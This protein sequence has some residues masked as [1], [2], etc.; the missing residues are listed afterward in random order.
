MRPPGARATETWRILAVR[1]NG[2]DILLRADSASFALPT[3]A[4][5]VQERIAANIN[6]AVERD[7]GLRVI[8]LYEVTLGDH[9]SA[10]SPLY[11]AVAVVQPGQ[12]LPQGVSWNSILP[13][14]ADS[15]SRPEDYL[16]IHAFRSG[17]DAKGTE[18]TARP[19]LKPDWFAELTCWVRD[20]VRPHSF[21]LTG[22]FHQL[23]ASGTFSLIRFDTD[24]VPVWFKA[25]GEPN[26]RECPI[27]LALAGLCPP[28]FPR[29][30]ASEPRWNAWL[31]AHAP[32]DS[33]AAKAEVRSWETT[34]SS[35]ARLQIATIGET[36][37]LLKAGA[38][39][40]RIRTLLSRVE[41]F[42]QFIAESIGQLPVQSSKLL[43]LLEVCELRAT[44][45]LALEE[46]EGLG[47]MET[48]GHM[49]LNP[50]NIFCLADRSVFLDWAESF[51][52]CPIF[53]YEYLLQHFR[54][55]CPR[56][57]FLEDQIRNAYLQPWRN[58]L[59]SNEL[60]RAFL[61]SRLIALFGYAVTIWSSAGAGILPSPSEKSYLLSLVR[62]MKREAARR[63]K[64]RVLQ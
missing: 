49:D 11:H 22:K 64:E 20:A 8:S 55:T 35:L 10:G 41:A 39:D 2:G 21:C 50:G 47:I 24:Q 14:T 44:I 3:V 4:I 38:Y 56:E 62:K 16:A 48:V 31:T 33:L 37:R 34:A 60:D 61:P 23:N 46:F 15:M 45:R 26:L 57:P 59:S 51:V 53:S 7:L 43:T 58:L 54:R 19:F 6:Q 63:D 32:G 36:R 29:V 30:L 17:L 12:D 27:T 40:L 9:E 13:L 25:V 42:F 28:H 52:G 5:P 1:H 18:D